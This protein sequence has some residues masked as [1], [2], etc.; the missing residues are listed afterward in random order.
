MDDKKFARDNKKIFIGI[1]IGIIIGILASV[2]PAL[3]KTSGS[4]PVLR[5]L[6]LVILGALIGAILGGT[7]V[8]VL[9][10]TEDKDKAAMKKRLICLL[11]AS[12]I[13]LIIYGILTYV[14]YSKIAS[15]VSWLGLIIAAIFIQKIK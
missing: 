4:L 2:I 5:I 8:A 12:V 10:A 7:V 3:I 14:G 11:I 13:I 1:G 15:I 9:V 6:V